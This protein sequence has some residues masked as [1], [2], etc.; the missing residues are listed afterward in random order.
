M[1]G[2][3]LL[4]YPHKKYMSHL[5]SKNQEMEL[6]FWFIFLKDGSIF[7]KKKHLLMSFKRPRDMT[8]HF[9]VFASMCVSAYAFPGMEYQETYVGFILLTI[10]KL[11]KKYFISELFLVDAYINV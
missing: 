7:T 11:E 8:K 2:G 3:P 6:L 9:L 5:F 4:S 10:L 1:S